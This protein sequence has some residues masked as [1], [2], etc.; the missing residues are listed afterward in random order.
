MNTTIWKTELVWFLPCHEA[1]SW[2]GLRFQFCPPWTQTLAVWYDQVLKLLHGLGVC[3]WLLSFHFIHYAT[4]PSPQTQ[5]KIS[6]LILL[7]F[8]ILLKII[9]HSLL[10]TL[11]S[12]SFLFSLY[13]WQYLLFHLYGSFLLPT[14]LHML[15]FL[16]VEFWAH[17]SSH[18]HS[19]QDT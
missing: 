10:E 8:F 13:T 19:L 18:F 17:C 2:P 14:L 7:N 4:I 12:L 1:A 3:V 5:W 9:D 15:V 16:I 6:V 11:P